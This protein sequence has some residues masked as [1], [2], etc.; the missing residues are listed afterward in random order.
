MNKARI[1][2]SVLWMLPAFSASGA[3]VQVAA[4]ADTSSPIYLASQ[5]VYNITIEN[6]D[7]IKPVVFREV[8]NG[9]WDYK[10]MV[11]P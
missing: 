3:Q 4:S 10:T 8:K 6:G 7:A 11:Y 1:I 9:K 5:F 2:I